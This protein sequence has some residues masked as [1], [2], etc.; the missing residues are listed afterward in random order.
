MGYST[1]DT[2]FQFEVERDGDQVIGRLR[3]ELDMRNARRLREALSLLSEADAPETVIDLAEVDFIDSSC[4]GVLVRAS[5]L[6]KQQAHRFVLQ[7][8][9]RAVVRA[10]AASGLVRTFAYDHATVADSASGLWPSRL[11][12]VKARR[13]GPQVVRLGT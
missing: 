12:A 2:I 13:R 11:P 3:G 7:A 8:P 4:L 5:A 6:C 10:L 9:S 1:N